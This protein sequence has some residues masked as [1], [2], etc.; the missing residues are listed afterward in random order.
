MQQLPLFDAVEIPLTKGY[1][2]LVDPCDADLAEYKWCAQTRMDCDLVYAV[3]FIKRSKSGRVAY[4]LHRIILSRVLGR[5][6]EPSELVDHVD[7]NGLNNQRSN[8]RLATFIEN[9]RNQRLRKDSTSGLKGAIPYRGKWR[10]SIKFNG[11]LVHLGDFSTPEE[12]HAAYC[13]AAKRY[14]GEFARTE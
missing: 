10:S 8:L 12:A 4:R 13:E 7:S 9:N 11:K 3:R 6:L 14:F 5:N 2:A 1:T